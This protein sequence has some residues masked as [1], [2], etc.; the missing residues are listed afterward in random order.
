MVSS[1]AASTAAE[2]S[3][4]PRALNCPPVFV[5]GCPRSGTTLL[6][7][8]LDSHPSLAIPDESHFIV[9]LY[10]RW[11]GVRSSPALAL[12]RVLAHPRFLRWGLDPAV[13]RRLAAAT[14]PSSYND[15]MVTVFAAYASAHGKPRWGDKTPPYVARIALLAELFAG[16]QFIHIIRDGREVAASLAAHHWG[17]STPMAAASFWKAQ[18]RKGRQAGRQL[19]PGCYLEV[20]LEE[21]IKEPELVLRTVCDFL[22]EPFA[23]AMLEYSRTA[24]QRVWSGAGSDPERSDHRHLVLPPTPG[25]RAWRAGLSAPDQRAV[26]A[27]AQPLLGALG[28]AANGPKHERSSTSRSTGYVDCPPVSGVKCRCGPA[29]SARTCAGATGSAPRIGGW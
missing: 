7:L 17:P 26:E 3:P 23:P 1:Q 16:A 5:V 9:D 22:H 20:R 6:R 11:L 29:A 28:Y 14:R 4:T 13:V 12:E 25:L 21:L 18:V 8:M 2:V 10:G 19:P 15:V 27:A 24:R